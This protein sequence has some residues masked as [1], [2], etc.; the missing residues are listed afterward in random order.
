MAAKGSGE[1]A[2]IAE[3]VL[4]DLVEALRH[5]ALSWAERLQACRLVLEWCACTLSAEQ[6]AAVGDA[7]LERLESKKGSDA[8]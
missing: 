5:E 3:G 8:E 2:S 7:L 4:Y 6:A 1:A